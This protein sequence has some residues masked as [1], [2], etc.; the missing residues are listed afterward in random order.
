MEEFSFSTRGKKFIMLCIVVIAKLFTV[1]MTLNSNGL[2][3][4]HIFVYCYYDH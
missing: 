1:A 3:W 2:S 4:H